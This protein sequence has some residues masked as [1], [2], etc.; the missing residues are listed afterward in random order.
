[1]PSEAGSQRTEGDTVT[2]PSS[3]VAPP[4][5]R[6]DAP[7]DVALIDEFLTAVDAGSTAFTQDVVE[8]VALAL[9]SMPGLVREIRRLRLWREA[10]RFFGAALA[11][12]LSSRPAAKA[13]VRRLAA[14]GF[15]APSENHLRQRLLRQRVEERAAGIADR[16]CAHTSGDG[17]TCGQEDIA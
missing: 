15:R 12:G 11:D 9:E 13:T 1:V 3:P 2:A 17:D 16:R 14:L 6:Y 10:E 5:C 8:E 7:A 4:S